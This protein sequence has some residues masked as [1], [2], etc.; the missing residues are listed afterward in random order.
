MRTIDISTSQ[1][2]TISYEIASFT[3]R[4]LA[5][6]IDALIIFGSILVLAI[7]LRSGLFD[8]SSE[9]FVIFVGAPIFL[10]YNLVCEISMDGQTPG[11][12]AMKLKIMKLDGSELSSSD[13]LVRWVFRSVDIYLSLG[14][15]CAM[16][17]S[18]S[19]YGQRLGGTLSHTAVIRLNPKVDFN[20]KDILSIYSSDKYSPVYTSVTK[21]SEP[22]VILIKRTVDRYGKY[23]NDAHRNAVELLTKKLSVILDISEPEE[24]SR[25][26]FL[27]TLI[28][29]Y[30]VL[31]R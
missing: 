4:L 20:L 5:Y 14:S 8:I 10:F 9:N 13:I 2:V 19:N 28:K 7:I 23:P 3:D 15:V 22:D 16:L 31:T 30:V 24:K 6:I 27:K 1:K 21:L 17:I 25:I 18:S 12:R 26:N 11:K 29:D